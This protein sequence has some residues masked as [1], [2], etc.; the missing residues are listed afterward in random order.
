M[1]KTYTNGVPVRLERKL[2][3]RLLAL[4][5]PAF[6]EVI[7]TVLEKDGYIN[8]LVLKNATW[9]ARN[10]DGGIDITGFIGA[11]HAGASNTFSC[12]GIP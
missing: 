7:R 3:E 10:G 5:Y 6:A 12:A 8:A 4:S 9:G 2:K 11:E 1:T